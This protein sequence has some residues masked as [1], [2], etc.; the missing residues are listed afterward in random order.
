MLNGDKKHA[1]G[2]YK[3]GRLILTFDYNKDIQN[4]DILFQN[5]IQ[6]NDWNNARFTGYWRVEKDKIEVEYFVCGN[7][8]DYIRKQGE[9]KGDTIFF[10]RDC[11][12][13]PFKTIKCPEKYV[14]S[15]MSF[16]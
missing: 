16:E 7:L 9:I 10:E 14:L 13:N 2:F 8:G 12:T 5:F 11:G 6:N 3:D 4:Y 15:D 1:F